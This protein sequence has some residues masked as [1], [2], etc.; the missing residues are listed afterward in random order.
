ME[1]KTAREPKFIITDE[2][3]EQIAVADLYTMDDVD[4][5]LS[6][7][8]TALPGETFIVWERKK[9]ATLT[10]PEYIEDA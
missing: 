10:Q 9:S 7:V 3:N 8:T 5:E 6:I 2:L 4:R 1:N